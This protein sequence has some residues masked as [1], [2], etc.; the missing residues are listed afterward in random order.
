M[1]R[2]EMLMM[3]VALGLVPVLGPSVAEAKVPEPVEYAPEL[4]AGE[5]A[6]G[7]TVVLDFSASWC[8]SCLAQGRAIQALRAEDPA[9]DAGLV[10]MRVDWDTWKDKEI[11]QRLEVTGRGAVVIL[12][13]DAIV[14]RSDTHLQ[15]DAMRTLLNRALAAAA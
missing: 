5:L 2:R 9:Y 15:Q 12:K 4:L 10:F 3:A 14:A 11:A 1:T 6:A 13:G 7:R 8:P